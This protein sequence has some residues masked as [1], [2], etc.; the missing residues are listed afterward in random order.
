MVPRYFTPRAGGEPRKVTEGV[1]HVL[2]TFRLG[3]GIDDGTEWIVGLDGGGNLSAQRSEPPEGLP[4]AVRAQVSF[5]EVS[6]GTRRRIHLDTLFLFDMRLVEQAPD[7]PGVNDPVDL[8]GSLVGPLAAHAAVGPLELRRTEGQLTVTRGDLLAGLAGG[9]TWAFRCADRNGGKMAR[10]LSIL[11][12]ADR[13]HAVHV[14]R[15]VV[16]IYPL[17]GVDADIYPMAPGNEEIISRLLYDLLHAWWTDAARDAPPALRKAGALPVP[18]RSQHERKLIRQGFEIR[19]DKAV[20]RRRG[21][22]GALPG[23]MGKERRALPPE[24]S[25]D[26]FLDL[27][28]EALSTLDD[29][30]SPSMVSLHERVQAAPGPLGPPRETNRLLDALLAAYFSRGAK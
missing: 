4:S 6:G 1:A 7:C 9:A 16:L 19:R 10:V 28:V 23:V 27:A 22:T 21:W 12:G 30:L 20:R 2:D 25:A 8:Y 5:H 17:L 14:G 24:G 29:W 3:S 13:M 18:S 26:D 15:G 11:T